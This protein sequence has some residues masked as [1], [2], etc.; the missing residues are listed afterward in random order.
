[1]RFTTLA[2][3]GVATAAPIAKPQWGGLSSLFG[4][5]ST[6]KAPAA[7]TSSSSGLGAL[8][9]LFGG[10][11][12]SGGSGANAL[13]GLAGLFGGGGSS[14]SSSASSGLSG[15]FSAATSGSSDSS[16]IT[17]GYNNIRNKV[18]EVGTFVSTLGASVSSSDISKLNSLNRGQI[19]ALKGLATGAQGMSG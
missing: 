14:G 11:G 8:A 16:I 15:L 19:D 6:T 1:M 3:V 18:A 10:G 4:G 2:L 7:S 12:S 13:S 9:G 5:S 17:N